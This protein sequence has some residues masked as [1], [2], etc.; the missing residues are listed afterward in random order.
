MFAEMLKEHQKDDEEEAGA[1]PTNVDQQMTSSE[2]EGGDDDKPNAK[3]NMVSLVYNAGT[4]VVTGIA[5]IMLWAFPQKQNDHDDGGAGGK[6]KKSSAER[7]KLI[8]ESL[9]TGGNNQPLN[10]QKEQRHPT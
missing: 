7:G 10:A 8:S 2:S 4:A 1:E 9:S 6:A 3:V 5:I